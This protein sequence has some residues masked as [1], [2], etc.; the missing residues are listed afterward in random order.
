MDCKIKQITEANYTCLSSLLKDRTAADFPFVVSAIDEWFSGKNRFNRKGELLLGLFAG[1]NC[2]GICGLNIDPYADD[3][4][5]G[6]VRHLFVCEAY[7]RQGFG[8]LL[9]TRIIEHASENFYRI[10]LYT[11]SEPASC[12]YENMGFI[13]SS[14]YKESHN[15]DL[16]V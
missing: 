10:R 1:D 14:H 15:M 4:H 16:K 6:R 12:L 7:R 13:K 3:L 2:V 8:K 5:L 9:L 11:D